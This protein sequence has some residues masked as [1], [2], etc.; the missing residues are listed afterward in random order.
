VRLAAQAEQRNACDAHKLACA[1]QERAVA[2]AFQVL[3]AM[4]NKDYQVLHSPTHLSAG[5]LRAGLCNLAGGTR[6]TRALQGLAV[7]QGA[8][9]RTWRGVQGVW[10][11]LNGHEWSGDLA[12][13]AAALA[14]KAGRPAPLAPCC[15]CSAH[16]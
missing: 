10:Q 3:Q 8:L 11:A 13:L 9:T 14:Q 4:W 6:E 15:A 16:A 5:C 7:A 2:V 1:L 12:P